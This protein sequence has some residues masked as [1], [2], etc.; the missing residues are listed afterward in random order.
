[1]PRFVADITLSVIY[2][3]EDEL[4]AIAVADEYTGWAHDGI[5][6]IGVTTWTKVEAYD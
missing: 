6:V 3:A 2:E 1:M 4:E 5:P